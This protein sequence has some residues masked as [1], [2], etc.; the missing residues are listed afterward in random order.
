M[1]A[2]EMESQA[3]NLKGQKQNKISVLKLW[4]LELVDLV[5]MSKKLVLSIFLQIHLNLVFVLKMHSV[6]DGERRVEC[7]VENVELG[8][9]R[10]GCEGRGRFIIKIKSTSH[11]EL[12]GMPVVTVSRYKEKDFNLINSEQ[13]KSVNI[14][15]PKVMVRDMSKVSFRYWWELVEKWRWI[16]KEK[17]KTT[18]FFSKVER[19][20]SR[21]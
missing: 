18:P 3:P 15:L 14:Y 11:K 5:S 1:H 7:F 9:L 16:K 12:C 20:D 2:A 17:Q 4:V 6:R 10:R 8:V 21:L 19:E 13:S